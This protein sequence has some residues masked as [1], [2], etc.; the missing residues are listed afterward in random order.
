MDNRLK[1]LFDALAI[2]PHE[3]QIP[4]EYSR[5]PTGAFCCVLE[6]D[7]LVTSMPSH[8]SICSPG[9]DPSHVVLLVRVDVTAISRI[10]ATAGI[11]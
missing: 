10:N 2:P 9:V 3:N 8:K 4:R 11:V 5:Q 1:T 7:S 6:D